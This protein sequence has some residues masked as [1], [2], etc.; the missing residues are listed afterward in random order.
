MEILVDKTFF[1]DLDKINNKA[2][3]PKVDKVIEEIKGLQQ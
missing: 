2:L 1:K 3:S